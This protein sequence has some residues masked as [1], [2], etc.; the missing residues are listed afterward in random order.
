MLGGFV[1]SGGGG[2]QG[3]RGFAPGG[4]SAPPPGGAGAAGG[5]GPAQGCVGCGVGV[6]ACGVGSA[7]ARV[8]AEA[9]RRAAGRGRE[10]PGVVRRRRRDIGDVADAAHSMRHDDES[11]LR[12]PRPARPPAAAYGRACAQSRRQMVRSDRQCTC[13][14]ALAWA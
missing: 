1:V 6:G 8:R 13:C 2:A 10:H 3:G 5:V 12:E 7:E 14:S 9:T 11:Q 4:G